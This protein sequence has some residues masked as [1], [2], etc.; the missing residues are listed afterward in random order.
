MLSTF[1]TYLRPYRFHLIVGPLLKLVEAV[2]ELLLPIYMARIIDEGILKDD[3]SVVYTLG[4]RMGVFIVVGLIC[5]TICQY[6]ASVASQG[7]GML[8][9][10]AL[11]SHIHKIA[12]KELDRLG[13]GTLTTRLTNDVTQLQVAVAMTVRLISRAPFVSVGCIVMAIIMDRSLSVIIVVGVLSFVTVLG[14][15]MAAAFP[16]FVE[17]QGR[18]DDVSDAV[19]ENF[20]GVRVIR[21]FER[22]SLELRKF[23]GVV[24]AHKKSVIR[25]ARVSSFMNPTTLLIMNLLICGI[26]WF[27]GESVRAGVSSPSTIVAF[28]NY[29]GLILTALMAVANLVVIF[30]R[31]AAS[32]VRVHEVFAIPVAE[33]EHEISSEASSEQRPE[34]AP[35]AQPIL[36]FS[37]VYF[38]YTGASE[39]DVLE[40]LDFSIPAGTTL[41]V[42]GG[43]GSGKTTMVSLILGFYRCRIGDIFYRDI[44]VE[45]WDEESL[46][47]E[48]APVFQN[49]KLFSGTIRENLAWSLPG[50]TEADGEYALQAAQ[51]AEFVDLN[52]EKT[53]TRVE[54]GGVN[55]SGGQ[56]QR[57]AIAM[58]L[59]RKPSLLLLDDASSA[60]DSLT[61]SRL[62]AAIDN[63][64]R[65]HGLTVLCI[66]QRIQ[67]IKDAEQI[68]VLHEGR[69]VGLGTHDELMQTCEE[70]REI[71][72]SQ[73]QPEEVN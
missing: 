35:A 69:Q 22:V 59:V 56:K 62:R 13:A 43:T 29:V 44:P 57:L 24:E 4:M 34:P 17:A 20:T 2:F 42:I 50:A 33:H 63:A 39:G 32:M 52:P 73:L 49:P 66:S 11:F 28:I 3:A 19:R 15:I 48:M 38:S 45:R 8:T 65:E 36:R 1:R 53:D 41:G 40:D 64:K 18:L 27:G 61:E 12:F 58:A 26:L 25:V 55:F 72:L 7:F 31:A 60:L 23:V 30:T 71:A 5:T 10:N 70:Y 37:H 14:L 47:R 6:L 21:A 16:L 9:G 46:R 54:R 67:S 68:L 51:A